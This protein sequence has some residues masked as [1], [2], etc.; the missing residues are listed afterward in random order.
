MGGGEVVSGTERTVIL[1]TKLTSN[2]SFVEVLAPSV[3][4]GLALC[5]KVT[6]VVV[7]GARTTPD[8]SPAGV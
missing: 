5:G 2:T 6:P 7:P 3:R 8:A 1:G 4:S